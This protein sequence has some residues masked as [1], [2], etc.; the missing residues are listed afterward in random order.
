M[1]VTYAEMDTLR[2]MCGL[3][4]GI[5]CETHGEYG[6]ILLL[7]LIASRSRALNRK[8]RMFPGRD[9]MLYDVWVQ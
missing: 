6:S 5:Q 4:E 8:R 2:R 3:W 9:P 1:R 7:F